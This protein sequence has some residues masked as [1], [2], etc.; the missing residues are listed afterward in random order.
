M[1]E[2]SVLS[3]REAER[4]NNGCSH[5]LGSVGVCYRSSSIFAPDVSCSVQTS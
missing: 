3:S 4:D 2:I 5:L 1:P